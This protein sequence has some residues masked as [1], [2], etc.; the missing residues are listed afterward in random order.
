GVRY[1]EELLKHPTFQ[2]GSGT[3]AVVASV[4]GRFYAM[5]RDKRWDRIEKAFKAMTGQMEAAT[6]ITPIQAIEKSYANG[7][8]DEFVEPV[9]LDKN[10]A[11]GDGD[12][13]LFYNFRADRA[14]EITSALTSGEFNEFSRGKRPILS[15][16]AGMTQ[17]DRSWTLPAVFGPQSFSNIFGEWLEQRDL[18]QLRIAET[19]KYAHVT[20]FFNGGREKPFQ[21]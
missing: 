7:K 11:M 6:G 4:M 19:E 21:N 2:E 8:T 10:A 16:F 17:Y 20:F 3:R 13:V 15:A 12:S 9:L 5:D 14:R 1:M 18:T